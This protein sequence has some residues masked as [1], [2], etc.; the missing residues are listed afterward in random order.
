MAVRVQVPPP[1]PKAFRK[2][3]QYHPNCKAERQSFR[4]NDESLDG[5]T[6]LSSGETLSTLTSIAALSAL[7]TK[8]EFLTLAFEF[9][10]GH[11]H[12]GNNIGPLSAV[13]VAVVFGA[14]KCRSGHRNLDDI[15][16]GNIKSL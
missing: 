9:L 11:L 1:A 2:K 3:G 10:I 5:F 7:N 16:I 6:L 8:A 14:L 15:Q 12:L 13:H 4:R